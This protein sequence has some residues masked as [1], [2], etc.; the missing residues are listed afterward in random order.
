MEW[1]TIVSMASILLIFIGNIIYI[2]YQGGYVKR[3]LD[4]HDQDIDENNR[5]LRRMKDSFTR[6]NGTTTYITRRE[7][8][9][10]EQEMESRLEKL[11]KANRDSNRKIMEALHSLQT[12]LAVINQH[13]TDSNKGSSPLTCNYTDIRTE[14]SDKFDGEDYSPG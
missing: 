7:F 1:T 5:E 10:L 4:A 9:K 11:E 6:E 2:S 13:L 3:K 8:D 12:Q 14:K